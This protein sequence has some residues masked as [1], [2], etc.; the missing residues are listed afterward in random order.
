[1]DRLVLREVRVSPEHLVALWARKRG[2]RGTLVGASVRQMVLAQGISPLEGFA[3]A[4]A[5]EWACSSMNIGSVSHQ[6]LLAVCLIATLGALVQG[7]TA[8]KCPTVSC[9]ALTVPGK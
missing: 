8:L 2:W 9:M 7:R 4:V 5:Q 6:V 1:M 3:T